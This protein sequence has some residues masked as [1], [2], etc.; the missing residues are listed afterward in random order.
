[1]NKLN[2]LL[3]LFLVSTAWVLLFLLTAWGQ[4]PG[5]TI[6]GFHGRIVGSHIENHVTQTLVFFDFGKY[7]MYLCD[8]EERDP[9][10]ALSESCCLQSRKIAAKTFAWTTGLADNYI[11][12]KDSDLQTSSASVLISK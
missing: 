1:M 7:G 2:L 6:N 8:H 12:Q 10:K 3:L 5:V 11:T 9:E 4:S